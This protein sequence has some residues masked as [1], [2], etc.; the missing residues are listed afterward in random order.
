MNLDRLFAVPVLYLPNQS[1]EEFISEVGLMLKRAIAQRDLLEGT[2]SL[3]D[4]ADLLNDQDFD[5]ALIANDWSEG[6]ERF[7]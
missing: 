1:H 2:I 4:Y 6:L 3:E 7:S 5:V